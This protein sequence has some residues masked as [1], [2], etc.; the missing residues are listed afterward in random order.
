MFIEIARNCEFLIVCI[1][2]LMLVANWLNLLI[3]WNKETVAIALGPDNTV[4]HD[5]V[6]TRSQ[7][8][9]NNKLFKGNCVL[10]LSIRP[11]NLNFNYKDSENS[12]V[13]V[14]FILKLG[15]QIYF[16]FFLSRVHWSLVLERFKIFQIFKCHWLGISTTL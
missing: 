11:K 2:V 4:S 12:L 8:L 15:N 5:T 10:F 7:V 13:P 1:N 9:E 14:C 16:L 6:L 3:M